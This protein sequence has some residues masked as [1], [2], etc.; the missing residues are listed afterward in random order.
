MGE[1][2]RRKKLGMYPEQTPKEAP[3]TRIKPLY[4]GYGYGMNVI[5]ALAMLSEYPKLPPVRNEL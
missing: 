4:S 2:S 5:S 1:A 3:K